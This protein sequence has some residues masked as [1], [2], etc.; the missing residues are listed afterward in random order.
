MRI[1]LATYR[2]QFNRDFT[3]EKA[4]A[5]I[6]YLHALGITDLYASPL[7]GA[8]S[9]SLHCYDVTDPGRLNPELG[10]EEEFEALIEELKSR[11][12]GLVLDIVP[13]HM[14]ASP[15]N[16][17]WAD[18]LENG[19]AS[20][21][22]SYF[23]IDWHPASGH[24]KDQVLL[25]ILGDP[26]GQVL[27]QQ[28]LALGLDQGGFYVRYWEHRFPIN[29]GTYKSVL[30]YRTGSESGASLEAG[31]ELAGLIEAVDSLPAPDPKEPEKSSERQLA[32]RSIKERLWRLYTTSAE[33][34][35]FIDENVRHFNG[36]K[37]EA[38]SFSL[39]DGLLK[40]QAYRLV[41]WRRAADQINYRRFFDVSDL[42]SLRVEDPRVFEATHGLIRRLAQE[43][44]VTGL[45]IDHIDGLFDPLDY[46]RRLQQSMAPSPTEGQEGPSFYIVVEKVLVGNETL[47]EEWPVSGT[48]GYEFLNTT[49]GVFVNP[50]GLGAL[51]GIYSKFTGFET[52]FAD[53]SHSRKKM[54]LEVL[55]P[56]EV[57]RLAHHLSRLAQQDRQAFDLPFDE[58]L[59]ALT[60]VTA[61]L[62]VYRTYIRSF[63]V[64]A[65]DR[66]YIE[67]AL[68]AARL[69]APRELVSPRALAFLRRV[70]L[71]DPE[72]YARDQKEAWLE[73]IMHWQQLTGPVKAKGLEDTALYMYH[74][75]ISL[76]E[77]GSDPHRADLPVDLETFHHR[78]QLKLQSW[79][80]S[81]NTSSTHD[82]KRSEGVR[83]RINV[84]SEIPRHWRR[85]LNRWSRLNAPKKQEAEGMAV[86][87]SN[88][89]I[90]IYQTMIGAWPF[91]AELEE[92]FRDRLKEYLVKAAREAK[93]HS[94]WRRPNQGYESAL[95]SFVD[96]I[97]APSED[98]EFLEDFLKFQKRVAF[99]GVFNSLAQLV[100]KVASP[101]VPDFY[102]GS[103][104]WNFRLVDPDNRRPVN[105][106]K[107][108][109]AL[110]ELQS[111]EGE[112]LV[113]LIRELLGGWED[114]RLKLF[115]TY[116]ALNFRRSR[117]ELFL[118]GS[119]IPIHAQGRREENL[120]AFARNRGQ[121]WVVAAV[122]R[123]LTRL[124]T[125]GK[126]AVGR[127][128][129]G[130]TALLLPKEAPDVWE[131]VLTGKRTTA[132]VTDE[133]E[134][135]LP[136]HSV[137]SALPLGLLKGVG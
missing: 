14:A 23:D 88:M 39:L 46:L 51:A 131:N 60:E 33:F 82:T 128:F 6:P 113:P 96:A 91:L 73:F 30:T 12:M 48:T 89:E 84:L 21:Y 95:L 126:V 37:G 124:R 103:E 108:K 43:G 55:F 71:L 132:S 19:P 15:E 86:P 87:D 44:K 17:W 104:F 13:N 80:Y 22:A 117:R 69:W 93:V 49:N 94:S 24:I 59:Q 5:L 7:L 78:N 8:R 38:E 2:L 120:C 31:G 47:P 111:R 29:V 70:L 109:E 137:F 102:Q 42:V 52:S 133:G 85:S 76:K 125:L 65:R 123:W 90:L 20:P 58:L 28:E 97:L 127:A 26:Y 57:R 115:V 3:F 40:Q 114:G 110:E 98:N 112:G 118:E 63:E 92:D 68:E 53:I 119:Y 75:L 41:F 11:E 36:I 62:P 10:T 134:R 122:P 116:R 34:K 27:E 74:R 64:S 4:R 45:R 9:G 83:A 25:P 35:G 105:F 18:V 81:L 136:I 54:V 66:F 16:P 99:Y 67:R 100:I 72:P 129:W 56:G 79:P 106:A 135:M 101:G 77:V 61:C 32:C 130:D 50:E 107:R 121:E 1:P